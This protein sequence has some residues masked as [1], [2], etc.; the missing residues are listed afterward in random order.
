MS[1][2][3]WGAKD[4]DPRFRQTFFDPHFSTE[5]AEYDQEYE[6]TFFPKVGSLRID[7][8]VN[9]AASTPQFALL[10]QLFPNVFGELVRRSDCNHA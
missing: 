1:V 2:E 10:D 7:Q 4:F 6:K 9:P 3:K 5:S 8:F